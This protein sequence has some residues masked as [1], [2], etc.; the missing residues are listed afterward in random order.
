MS[1]DDDNEK[2][3]PYTDAEVVA[4]FKKRGARLLLPSRALVT[5]L[6]QNTRRFRG[7]F[8]A[9]LDA[10]GDPDILGVEAP[11]EGELNLEARS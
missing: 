5:Y 8:Y 9:W 6:N 3:L 4:E 7:R 11:K 1:W 10:G 2:F